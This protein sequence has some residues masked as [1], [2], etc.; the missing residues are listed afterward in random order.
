MYQKH[1]MEE[2]PVMKI[3]ITELVFRLNKKS[4]LVKVKG[5]KKRKRKT[6]YDPF[7]NIKADI[8]GAV[9][10]NC[11]ID[12]NRVSYICTNGTQCVNVIP[13]LEGFTLPTKVVLAGNFAYQTISKESIHH[14]GI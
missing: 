3:T 7:F 2:I 5:Q 8:E 9:M 4:K 10:G 14:Y 6:T 11:Y 12:E 13:N 1:E